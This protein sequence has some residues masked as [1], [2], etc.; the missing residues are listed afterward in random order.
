MDKFLTL[1]ITGLCAAGIFAIAASGLVL[2]YT[3]TGIFNFSH[4]AIGMLGAFAYWQLRSPVAWGLPAPLALFLV[5]F[6]LAPLLGVLLEVVIMRGLQG[7]SD[8]TKLVVSIS[9]LAGMLELGRWIWPEDQSH[10]IDRFFEGRTIS[11]LGVNVTWHE[12][13][14]LVLAVVVAI[15]LRLL[16]FNTRPGI[17]MRASVDDRPLAALH[18]ARPDRSAMLAWA[19]G[20]SLAALAGILTAPL[21]TLSHTV[22]TLLI[23]NAYAAAIIGRLRSLPLTFLGSVILGL[24]DAYATGY[25]PSSNQYFSQF[26][27]AVPVAILFVVLLLLRDSK[28]RG[29]TALRTR[30]VIPRPTYRGA[31]VGAVAVVAVT[32][33]VAAA[34]TDADAQTLGK[35]FGFAL[36]AA[37]LVPLAGFAGQISLCQL[38]F[39][40]IGALAMA[41]HG[42][43]GS[44]VGLVYAAV[45]A[46]AVGAVVALPAL[47][48]SGIYLALATAAFAVILDRWLFLIP[49]FDVGPWKVRLFGSS[50]LSVPTLKIPGVDTGRPKTLLVMLAVVFGLFWLAVVAIRRSRFGERLLAMKD[51]PAACATL[52]MNTT[53]TK[54][55]VFSLSAA[56]AGVGGAFYAAAQGGVASTNFSFFDSLPLLLLVVVGGIGTAGGALFAGLVSVGVP[57]V[58]APLTAI[59]GPLRLLPGL[60]GVGLGRN[61]NGAVGDISQGFRPLERARA[62]VAALVVVLA[63]LFALRTIGSLSNWTFA[64]LAAAAVVCA[65][66]VAQGLDVRRRSTRG[67]PGPPLEWVGIDRPFTEDDLI[68]LDRSLA[69]PKVD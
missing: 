4:G 1:S 44:P 62:I 27:A 28:L 21:L 56:M 23:V 45:F 47:R 33:A 46:G 53:M 2:T 36:V 9:L 22:L 18:G 43:G 8:T 59:Q 6:V 19:I 64:A 67:M 16:L 31:V 29:H 51:S 38:S 57:L 58:A 15:G 13:L 65:L 49:D 48:L 61:P 37:S 39:A 63:A 20:C 26:R 11:V 68:A 54:L 60:M 14:G 55:A 42:G 50:N 30:E 12:G 41:Y 5:L 17:A 7:T 10:P 35:L 52:G 32:V 25:I 69:L 3:T 24:A 66:A 34:V 40:A